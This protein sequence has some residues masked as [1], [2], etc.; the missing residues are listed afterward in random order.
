[1]PG[2][3]H[4]QRRW[5]RPRH[6]AGPG[7]GPLLAVVPLNQTLVGPAAMLSIVAVGLYRDGLLIASRLRPAAAAGAC[8]A[9]APAA[10]IFVLTV[11]DDLT[12]A[13][14]RV[15]LPVGGATPA[16]DHGALVQQAIRPAVPRAARAVWL[17]VRLDAAGGTAGGPAL[18]T[19]TIPLNLPWMGVPHGT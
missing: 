5:W 6:P 15:S 17:N 10:R 18:R 19:W 4:Q 2:P 14:G 16:Y 3:G 11:R 8:C 7:L 9:T 13:Y 12:T 1:M